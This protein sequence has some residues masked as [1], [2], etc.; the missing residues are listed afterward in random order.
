MNRC[1]ITVLRTL[2]YEDLAA[3]YGV[4]GVGLCPMHK[5]GEVFYGD[6][7]KPA[8]MCDEAWKAMYQYVFALAHGTG[9]NNDLFY[10]NSWIRKPG[11]AICTCND[12][13]RPVVFKIERTDE[14]AV[15]HY[16]PLSG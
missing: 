12:G 10:F 14:P 9:A 16:E 6:Y 3:E 11:V 1:R 2:F 13:I 15:R 4:E 5:E 8:G 7:T